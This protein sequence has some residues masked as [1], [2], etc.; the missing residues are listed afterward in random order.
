[1]E[2]Q[3][4]FSIFGAFGPGGM[5]TAIINRSNMFAE[6]GHRCRVVTLDYGTGAA[7]QTGGLEVRDRLHSSVEV[8]NP[9]AA[10][11]EL[12]TIVQESVPDPALLAVHEEGR[13]VQTDEFATKHYARYFLPDGNYEKYKKWTPDH[14]RLV[15]IDYFNQ[16]KV[17]YRREEFDD[18][19]ILHREIGFVGGEKNRERYLTSDGFCYLVRWY[20]AVTGKGQSTYRFDRGQ[21]EV[22]RYA[23]CNAWRVAWLQDL[24]DRCPTRPMILADGRF[25][26]PQLF[27]LGAKTCTLLAVMHSNHY[28]KAPFTPGSPIKDYYAEYLDRIDEVDGVVA[29]TLQQAQD[30]DREAGCTGK[31]HAI[32]NAIAPRPV[33]PVETVPGR[34]GMFGRIIRSKG[35]LDAIH[36]WPEVLRRNPDAKLHIFGS[37]STARD[38]YLRE[39]KAAISDLNL[40]HSVK[41]RGYT[42]DVATETATCSVT[43]LPSTTEGMPFAVVES[44]LAETPVVAYDCNYGPRD[45]ITDEIDGFLIPIADRKALAARI[46]TLLDDTEKSRSMGKAGRKKLVEEYSPATTLSRWEELFHRA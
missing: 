23:S 28:S 33:P 21:E 11:R 45:L 15:S 6:A 20:D 27:K 26:M 34:V 12:N 39:V 1:M 18:R 43:L 32:P 24:V 46:C 17:I 22:I 10:A 19:G 30:V 37:A 25:V 35:H 7:S 13:R 36:T 44:M 40:S 8:L 38:P 4:V 9:F 41:L 3:D 5:T 29:L 2:Q 42:H 31:V 14:S 16:D